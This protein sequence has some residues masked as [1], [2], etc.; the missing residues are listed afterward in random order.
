MSTQ[1]MSRRAIADRE[2]LAL[3][4]PLD[5]LIVLHKIEK[6]IQHT[7]L[8]FSCFLILSHRLAHYLSKEHF[9]ILSQD[10]ANIITHYFSI[11]NSFY[12]LA[13]LLIIWNTLYGILSTLSHTFSLFY[14]FSHYL[15]YSLSAK[16]TF[17]FFLSIQHTF[18]A[19][20]TLAQYLP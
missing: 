12:N 17:L 5:K 10:L 20:S 6:K 13:L 3:I 15:A 19:F 2:V 7:F 14:A 8:K 18:S 4:D 16:H 1:L 11:L 9:L